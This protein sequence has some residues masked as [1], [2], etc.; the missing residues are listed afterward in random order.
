M[1]LQLDL[2]HQILLTPSPSGDEAAAA[3]LWRA[4]A[5]EF[6]DEVQTDV[7]GNSLAIL[8]GD[9]LRVLLD[10]HIDE[11]GLMISYI[12]EDGFL[13]FAQIGGWDPQVLVGQRVVIQGRSTPVRGVVG[14]I[15]PHLLKGDARTTAVTIEGL[16]IDIGVRDKAEAQSLVRV[17]ATAV[18]DAPVLEL[19]NGRLAAHGL[20]NRIGAFVVHQALRRLAQDRPAATVAALASTHEETGGSG[21]QA[22][23]FDFNPH[24]ALVV[25]VTF[26]TDDPGGNKQEWGEVGLGTG[27]VL[28]R[29]A[30]NSPV[31]YDMLCDVAERAAI[32]YTVQITASRTGTNADL[33]YRLRGSTA[34]A[35]ISVPN[36]YMHS[37]SEMIQLSDVE[38]TVQLIVAF[39][40]ELTAETSTLR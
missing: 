37:P 27:P 14:R 8:H 33:I 32:P 9:G 6:A 36:R 34:A 25:D 24:V 35:I 31:L 2:L 5:K 12:S 13:Y 40:R 39:V 20:D 38:Q 7:R 16:W 17:G 4:A 10:G 11:I 15:P 28:S 19:P 3:A 23:A 18:I 29:G 26:T 21:A 30:A 1:D 22:A